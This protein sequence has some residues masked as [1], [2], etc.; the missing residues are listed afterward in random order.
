MNGMARLS[1][2]EA[3]RLAR[4]NRERPSIEAATERL[5][6][7]IGQLSYDLS[8]LKRDIDGLSRLVRSEVAPLV[9]TSMAHQVAHEMRP[10][11]VQQ[12]A[13][14]HSIHDIVTVPLSVA[15]IG[16]AQPGDI[17]SALFRKAREYIDSHARPTA[18]R[19]REQLVMRYFLSIPATTVSVDVAQGALEVPPSNAK[20]TA[21]GAKPT[22][23]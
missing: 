6:H 4:A 1:G 15:L 21:A 9:F 5:H 17:E 23:V 13:K 2:L 20:R 19:D 11:I 14:L 16:V 3:M 12:L 22:A 18:R 8:G 10:A 7:H